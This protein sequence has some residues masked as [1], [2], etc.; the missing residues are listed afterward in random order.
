M[1][2]SAP[3]QDV[4]RAAI[5]VDGS[6]RVW[7]FYSANRKGNFD[8]YLCVPMRRADGRSNSG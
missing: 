7:V 5:A 4:M 6:K 8:I 1:P 2:V 3:G